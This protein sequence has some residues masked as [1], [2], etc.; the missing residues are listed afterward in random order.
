MKKILL[1]VLL[2]FLFNTVQADLLYDITDGKF[3]SKSIQIPL[4]MEDGEHYTTLVN[5][6]AIVK[7]SY[8]TGQTIDTIF[9]IS[10]LKNFPAKKING[11]QFSPNEAK[12]LIYT[13]PEY[14]YRRS[15]TANYYVVDIKRNEFYPLSDNAPQEAPLFSPDSR[16]IAF[17]HKNNL[18][19]HKLD[20]KTEIQI[21]KDG[22]ENKII[23]G[24][25][26][27]VY[28]EEFEVTRHF[29]WS[30]DSKLLAFLKFDEQEVPEFSFQ[31]F[32]EPGNDDLLLYPK[33]TKFKY[34]KAGQQN[35]KVKVCVYDDFNK[36]TKVIPLKDDALE[37]YYIPRIK[38]TNSPEELVIFKLNRTQNQLDMLFANPKSGISKLIQRQEDKYY[39]NYEY[40]DN[41][42]FTQDKMYYFMMSEKD[43]FAHLYQYR[44]NGTLYKQITK[45]N[46]DVTDFYGIDE[47]TKS[48][49]FQS[50][51]NSPM[52]RDIYKINAKGIKTR[53]SSDKGTNNAYFSNGFQY[54]VLSF[55]NIKTPAIYSVMNNIGMKIRTIES[56]TELNKK[57][58]ELNMPE[59]KFFSFTTSEN[60]SLNGWI[61]EPAQKE[62]GK[63][64]PVVMVQYSG[65]N[66]QQVLDR[67][68][69]DWEYYLAEQGYIVACVDGRGTGARG[70]EFRK[71]TYKQMGVLETK[72]QIEAA[73]YLGS[74]P[75]ADKDRIAIW[76]W[77]YG[78]SMT[79]WAMCSGANVFKAGIAVA[80]VTDWR[81]YNT[82]YTERFMRTPQENFTG[83]DET[84]ILKKAAQLNGNLL[85]VH[86]TADDNV[87]VQNTL[88]FT[89]ELVKAGKQFEMQIYTDK[90]HS[91]PDQATRRHLYQRMVGFLNKN[92]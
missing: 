34:P 35:S 2:V 45:G 18:Y 28:E 23:N 10:R 75:Q 43:G 55:S 72:D 76:G 89:D 63:K 31:Y 5:Q 21:T 7:Y 69:F 30:P 8:K 88:L 64:Y 74:L 3:R 17:A 12:L 73:R 60:I 59:K 50:A 46:F 15:F 40:I 47:T 61:V 66:S 70:A 33:Q 37:G 24:I 9:S 85:I 52:T 49:Y 62:A 78:G 6:S 82:A 42:Y 41:L 58:R 25:A 80:P 71:C 53:I 54:F 51:E 27:W 56:N 57:V 65:P 22:V 86:G 11:Y 68:G 67:W 14:R 91:L 79:L 36:T 4:S 1:P 20:F 16:Y 44:M 39:I 81:L 84:S 87:H 29:S 90:N 77:S 48:I 83:Y 92:L 26:D 19:M 32:T 38:W 13:Q